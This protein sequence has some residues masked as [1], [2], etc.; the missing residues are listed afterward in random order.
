MT[1]RS[2]AREPVG[3]AR[4]ILCLV[5]S[6]VGG[7][8]QYTHNLAEALV[9][10]GHEVMVAGAVDGELG[11]F[12]RHYALLEVFHRRPR[13]GDILRLARAA[14][15]FRPQVVHF[16]GA[17]RPEFYLAAWLLL[18]LL[19]PAVFVWT[20]QDVLSN[21]HRP[22]HPPLFRAAYG[23]MRHVFLNARQNRELVARLFGVEAARTTVLPMP[24]LVAFARRD[25][26]PVPPPVPAGRRVVLC[27]GLIEPRKGIETLIAAFARL[28]ERVPEA[29]LV[30]AGKPLIDPTPYRAEIERRG[31]DNDSLLI[32][33]YTSFAEMAGLFETA[34][35]V[36]LPYHEG[37]NS[38]VLAAAFGFQR[39]VVVSAVGGFEEV[40][41]PERT[42]L[43][44]PP[45]DADALAEA[46]ERVLSEPG[47]GERLR[48][49]TAVAA[50]AASWQRVAAITDDVYDR[51]LGAA[52]GA[53][54]EPAA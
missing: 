28:R 9:E 52:A 54:Q 40:V 53:V 24:D 33:R 15:R 51:V 4:R 20:P 34:E 2:A 49:G 10:R 7:T 19:T 1:A 37:W 45:R 23:R 35:V 29:F 11:G 5:P 43:V 30:I 50:A 36:T 26:T 21:A 8:P 41:E 32:P 6:A 17:Q 27:F 46:L 31:L 13:P 39:P 22:W 44:V 16:Q 18:R 47:L 42:G 25:L 12:V 48:A 14:R 3:A 38:G